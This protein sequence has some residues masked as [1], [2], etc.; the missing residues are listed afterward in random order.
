MIINSLHPHRAFWYRQTLHHMAKSPHNGGKSNYLIYSKILKRDAPK[1]GIAHQQTS[2][3]QSITFASTF[4]LLHRNWT[5]QAMKETDVV[6]ATGNINS[7][8][9]KYYEHM[10]PRNGESHISKPLN[11]KALHLPVR[12]GCSI[13]TEQSR[14]WKKQTLWQPRET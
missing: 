6:A 8:L 13:E 9:S 14:P 11:I 10:M 2:E 7:Y 5:K 12:F 1:W 4:R 3:Y